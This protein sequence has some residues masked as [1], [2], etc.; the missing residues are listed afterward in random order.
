[1][2]EKWFLNYDGVTVVRHHNDNV[3]RNGYAEAAATQDFS[4]AMPGLMPTDAWFPL[5]W[6]LAHGTPLYRGGLAARIISCAKPRSVRR[7]WLHTDH[8]CGRTWRCAWLA[9]TA[10][11]L[12]H[13][14]I[15]ADRCGPARRGGA[16]PLI[17]TFGG[18][19]PMPKAVTS[20]VKDEAC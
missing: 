13:R 8:I 18:F 10:A 1:M 6:Q 4:A 14:T 15:L 16:V 9:Q 7:T 17:F 20:D 2:I 19:V 5:S 3:P 12:S 11:G